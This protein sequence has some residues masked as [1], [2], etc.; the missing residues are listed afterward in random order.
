MK[1]PHRIHVNLPHPDYVH[2]HPAREHIAHIP[3]PCIKLTA[4][5]RYR[6]AKK[7]DVGEEHLL[8]WRNIC[9]A[10][11]AMLFI[12]S[13]FP[14]RFLGGEGG[15][16]MLRGTAYVLGAGAYLFEML[17]IT[18]MFKHT[19]P[20]REMFM[21]YVFGALYIVLAAAYFWEV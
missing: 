12:A 14:I 15:V 6:M 9:V 4:V 2:R 3:R 5:K 20:V 16:F 21:A 13:L 7:P 17:M 1:R 10:A 18:D 19:H 11:A 8:S